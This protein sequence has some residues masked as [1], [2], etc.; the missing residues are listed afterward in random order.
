[1]AFF[2]KI[3]LDGAG[4][5]VSSMGVILRFPEGKRVSTCLLAATNT[6]AVL[7]FAGSTISGFAGFGA[8]SLSF[9][10]SLLLFSL[11]SSMLCRSSGFSTI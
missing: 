2:F 10:F 4:A 7:D 6:V 11:K 9:L 8:S 3:Y 1:M 5:G